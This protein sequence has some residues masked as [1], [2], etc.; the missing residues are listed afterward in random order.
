[1]VTNSRCLGAYLIYHGSLPRPA[2]MML[3]K[4]ANRD[5]CSI[6][7]KEEGAPGQQE[8]APGLNSSE[9]T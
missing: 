4:L 7:K 8:A 9:P 3:E 1:M 5:L 2:Y 6:G